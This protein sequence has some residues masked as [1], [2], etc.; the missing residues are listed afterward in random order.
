MKTS[1]TISFSFLF[2]LSTN[3]FCQLSTADQLVIYAEEYLGRTYQWGGCGSTG[4]GIDC[5]CFTRLVFAKVLKI[6]IP[7]NSYNQYHYCNES[8]KIKELK[9]LRKG[10]LVFFDADKSANIK[11]A[12]NAIDHVGIITENSIYGI[13][14]IHSSTSTNGVSYS[15]LRDNLKGS[16]TTFMEVFVGGCRK[17][18]EENT[19]R[20]TNVIMGKYPHVSRRY[21]TYSDFVHLSPEEVAIMRNEVFAR[22]G[23]QF[24]KDFYLKYFSNQKWYKIDHK[25]N[26]K[27]A[28]LT[29]IEKYNTALLMQYQNNNFVPPGRFPQT[30]LRKLTERDLEGLSKLD[31]GIMRNE[32]FARYGKIFKTNFYKNYF[33][34][35]S[36]YKEIP[37]RKGL[38]FRY[39]SEIEARNVC[40]IRATEQKLSATP[41]DFDDDIFQKE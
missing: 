12:P 28:K 3:L 1:L 38:E 11:G 34:S 23:Y 33:S 27:N 19:S 10:D 15:D 32:I 13:K 2:F 35:Q 37:F 9:S 8:D 7:R 25:F 20:V 17:I 4:G 39:L 14:M 30:A 41:D 21:L 5:S 18:E 29:T 36:W 40:I 31:L 6:N 22:Y 26:L 24:K 16:P